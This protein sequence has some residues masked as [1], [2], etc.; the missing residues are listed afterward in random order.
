M[1]WHTKIYQSH[2][3]CSCCC[4]MAKNKNPYYPIERILK[5]RISNGKVEYF[6]KWQDYSPKSNSWVEERNIKRIHRRQAQSK[7]S[8]MQLP[9]KIIS[10]FE[11]DMCLVKWSNGKTSTIRLS[12][13]EAYQVI[14]GGD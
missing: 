14:V 2:Q 12:A 5:K 6:V 11:D 7:K 9:I 1:I 3:C 8:S 10:R 13:R 4:T